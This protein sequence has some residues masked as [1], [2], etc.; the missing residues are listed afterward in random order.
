MKITRIVKKINLNQ[1]MD[2]SVD[3]HKDNLNF[4]FAALKH[5]LVN[6]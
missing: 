5:Q 6:L 2:I 3:D 1:V 4:F